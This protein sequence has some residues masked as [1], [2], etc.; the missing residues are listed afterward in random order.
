[1]DSGSGMQSVPIDGKQSTTLR[2][3]RKQRQLLARQ[4]DKEGKV[5]MEQELSMKMVNLQNECSA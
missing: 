2:N 5:K 1:M 4:R 3:A